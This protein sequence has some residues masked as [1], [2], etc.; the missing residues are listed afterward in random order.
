MVGE[1]G[2]RWVVGEIGTY[3]SPKPGWYRTHLLRPQFSVLWFGSSPPS[4]LV[5]FAVWAWF[6]VG[7]WDEGNG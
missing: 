6:A 4:S 7:E 1:I 3:R 5:F 2:S